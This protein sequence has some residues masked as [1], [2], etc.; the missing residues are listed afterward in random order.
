[1]AWRNSKKANCAKQ[2]NEQEREIV[3]TAFS[4]SFFSSFSPSD[5]FFPSHT[6][7]ETVGKGWNSSQS[8][9][10]LSG[11]SMIEMTVQ[12]RQIAFQT[13]PSLSRSFS[14]STVPSFSFLFFIFN[15]HPGH[16]FESLSR[17]VAVWCCRKMKQ[18]RE[19]Q[20]SERK[21]KRKWNEKQRR[22]R[23]TERERER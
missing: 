9:T 4:Y 15:E 3:P 12:R 18:R 7:D 1:M 17:R 16:F 20:A 14:L 8:M 5:S 22:V 13:V 6:T 11:G 21:R 23:K 2:H 19:R 10:K